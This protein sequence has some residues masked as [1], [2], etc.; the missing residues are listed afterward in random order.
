[1]IDQTFLVLSWHQTLYRNGKIEFLDIILCFLIIYL[2]DIFDKE[3]LRHSL[4]LFLQNVF[5]ILHE[6]YTIL[7]FYCTFGYFK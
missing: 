5:F 2:N 6:F 3:C 1:M 4:S 7:V